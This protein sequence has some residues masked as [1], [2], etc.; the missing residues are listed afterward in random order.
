VSILRSQLRAWLVAALKPHI[1]R[2]SISLAAGGESDW[3]VDCRPV[4]YGIDNGIVAMWVDSEMVLDVD[5][6]GGV[7]FG[8]LP[9]AALVAQRRQIRTFGVR[10]EVKDHG[11]AGKVVGAVN[12]GDRVVVVEDVFNTGSSVC[13]AI[14][15]LQAMGAVVVQVVCIVNRGNP[16]LRSV[17][18]DV[19]F[20]SL[21]TSADLQDA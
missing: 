14:E 16:A 20:V 12:P 10:S 8:G 9:V 17:Y 18:G 15:A 2:G 1:V 5:A 21:L 3:Y 13:G 4:L 6:V 19:P 7:G 11:L